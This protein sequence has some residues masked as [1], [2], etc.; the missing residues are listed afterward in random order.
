MRLAAGRIVADRRLGVGG[1][2]GAHEVEDIRPRGHRL[3][4][5]GLVLKGRGHLR[6]HDAGQPLGHRRSHEL[7]A[8]EGGEAYVRVRAVIPLLPRRLRLSL[9]PPDGQERRRQGQREAGEPRGNLGSQASSL[10]LHT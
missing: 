9:G 10:L 3:G 5:Q 4:A 2:A 7:A 6:G 1:L 8:G